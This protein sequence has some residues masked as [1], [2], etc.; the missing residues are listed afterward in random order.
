M[1]GVAVKEE[2][3]ELKTLQRWF[4]F[5][6]LFTERCHVSCLSWQVTRARTAKKEARRHSEDRKFVGDASRSRRAL[7]AACSFSIIYY[8]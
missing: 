7:Y 5:V 6:A 4:I 8:L 2:E 3:S 1:G